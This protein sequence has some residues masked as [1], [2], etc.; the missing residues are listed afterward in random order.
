VSSEGDDGCVG[1]TARVPSSTAAASPVPPTSRRPGHPG[2]PL[3][4]RISVATVGVGVLAVI[5][6]LMLADRA[7]GALRRLSDRIDVSATEAGRLTDVAPSD[8]WVHV[9][10]WGLVSLLF[11]FVIWSW[12]GVPFVAVTAFGMG[13]LVEVAQHL[14][15]ETRGFQRSDIVANA[16]GV[17]IGLGVF[18]CGRVVWWAWIRRGPPR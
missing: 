7:P 1:H 16:V 10:A 4:L 2:P 9:A 8:A 18:L 5:A 6:V 17:V 12:W 11:A 15:T 3:W 13:V 14:L